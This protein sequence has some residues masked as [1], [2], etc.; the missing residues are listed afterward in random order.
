METERTLAARRCGL[1]VLGARAKGDGVASAFEDVVARAL[2][3]GL[4][5]LGRVG[6]AQ[7]ALLLLGAQLVAPVC[8]KAAGSVR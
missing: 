8:T 6:V 5:A 4:L 2:L 7:R 1:L 3:E